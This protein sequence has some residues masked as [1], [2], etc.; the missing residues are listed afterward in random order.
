[1]R[2]RFVPRIPSGSFVEVDAGRIHLRDEGEV[3]APVVVLLHG[4]GSSLHWFDLLTPLL[5][6]HFRVIRLD[7][8]GFGCTSHD[9][10]GF[11]PR[12]QAAMVL[13]VL[14]ALEIGEFA[15]VGHSFGADVAINLAERAGRCP[16]VVIVGQAPDYTTAT[17]PRGHQLARFVPVAVALRAL[18]V[19]TPPRW[20]GHAFAPG[21][22]PDLAFPNPRQ[23]SAD[24]RVTHLRMLR[25]VVIDR[26][27]ALDEHPLDVQLKELRLPAMVILGARDQ[28]YPME[29]T[30]A[31]YDLV[32]G[33]RVEVIEDSGHS[34]IVEAP[35]EVARLLRSFLS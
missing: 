18:S 11:D 12:T 28:F 8:L 31:R 26:Q 9:A 23:L 14:D 6:E 21:F 32:R 35:D 4:F 1:M 34:P 10:A 24:L 16:A 22:R 17:L 30:R 19:L 3:S 29:P 25:T 7:L 20:G 27:V 33:L 5:T 13:T 15:P 2:S